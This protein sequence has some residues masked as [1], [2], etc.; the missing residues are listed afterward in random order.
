[1]VDDIDAPRKCKCDIYWFYVAL[2]SF[3]YIIASIALIK[4]I[5]NSMYKP[6]KKLEPNSLC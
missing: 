1:M 5:Y 3:I 6:S 2:Y 4:I